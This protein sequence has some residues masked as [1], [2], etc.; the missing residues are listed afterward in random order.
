[1][2]GR[3]AEQ[4]SEALDFARRIVERL[5][6]VVN[7][8]ART[9]HVDVGLDG[10]RLWC[11][12]PTVE[13]TPPPLP[14]ETQIRVAA[15][16]HTAASLGEFHLELGPDVPRFPRELADALHRLWKRSAV[17]RVQFGRNYGSS[18]QLALAR[19]S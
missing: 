12:P 11:S 17:G 3:P 2:L 18:R 14:I 15:R 4:D 10:S 9:R 13:G 1:L 8:D 16:M 19:E 7:E 6:D 5:R